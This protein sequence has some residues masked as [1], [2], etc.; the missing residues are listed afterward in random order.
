VAVSEENGAIV[1]QHK[2]VEGGADRSYGVH[3]AELAGLPSG[4]VNR[5]RTLLRELENTPTTSPIHDHTPMTQTAQLQLFGEESAALKRL[6]ALDPNT[7]SPIEALTQ[8]FEL[9]KM[10]DE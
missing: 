3:V 1:F 4:V 7:L 5:A 8:L 9:K 6:R 2:V 10:A